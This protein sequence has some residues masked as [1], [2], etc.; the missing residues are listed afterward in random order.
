MI[1]VAVVGMDRPHYLRRTLAGLAQQRDA[2]PFE[3][4]L[5]LD[6]AVNE[7]SNRVVG[8]ASSIDACAVMFER[9]GLPGGGTF[10]QRYNLGI[11]L[12]QYKA[13]EWM[14]QRY[15]RVL[16]L[17][18]DVVL[19]PYWLRLLGVLF[20]QFAH[21]DDVFGFCPG[22][23]RLGRDESALLWWD[24]HWWAEGFTAAAWH[25]ARPFY[26]DYLNIIQGV[27]YAQRPHDAIRALFARHEWDNPSTSQDSGKDLAIHRS[28][29][30]RV[31]CAVNRAL[32]IGRTGVHFTPALF[33]ARGY[34]RPGT[35]IHAR[36]A[37]RERFDEPI[38]G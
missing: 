18:D 27:D 20:E 25:R 17:E 32:G 11:G 34:E 1:G 22:F 28:G 30:R 24:E 10:R 13:T 4:H 16:M 8:K 2:P 36:D 26:R 33:A 7:W 29:Q 19:S 6:G 14:C 12:H 9:A 38:D 3:V 37:T 15:E 31:C 23:K 5:W 35:H 21:R